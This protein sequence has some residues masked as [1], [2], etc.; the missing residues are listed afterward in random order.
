[1]DKLSALLSLLMQQ[2]VADTKDEASE[3]ERKAWREEGM[4]GHHVPGPCDG[5]EQ[6]LDG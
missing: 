4:D 3:R 6:K 2:T 5:H 1:M